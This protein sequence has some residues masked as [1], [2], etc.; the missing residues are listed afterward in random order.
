M[1]LDRF[2][3]FDYPPLRYL[4]QQAPYVPT[5][6]VLLCRAAHDLRANRMRLPDLD[7]KAVEVHQLP[8][9]SL[10]VI[11]GEGGGDVNRDLLEISMFGC[12]R[13]ERHG[14]PNDL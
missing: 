6:H 8:R 13:L 10:L 14:D 11:G 7:E 1:Q 12:N 4:G 5:H 9:N 2:D 3:Q